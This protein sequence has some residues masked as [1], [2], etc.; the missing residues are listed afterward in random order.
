MRATLP[1]RNS[2]IVRNASPKVRSYRRYLLI[3]FFICFG[4]CAGAIISLAFQFPG[5]AILTVWGSNSILPALLLLSSAQTEFFTGDLSAA[6]IL[7]LP[8]SLIFMSILPII[9]SAHTG[10]DRRVDT[11]LGESEHFIER[12]TNT[13]PGILYVYDLTEQRVVYLNHQISTILGYN[14]TE[15]QN[16]GRS[17]IKILVHPYYFAWVPQWIAI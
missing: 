8:L 3:I 11:S 2:G 9:L 17:L 1:D 16:M 5:S 14:Q 7:N 12:I 13:M 4:F 15:V 6:N 10:E